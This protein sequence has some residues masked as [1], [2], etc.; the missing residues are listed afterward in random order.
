MQDGRADRYNAFITRTDFR[1]K[2]SGSLSSLRI[3]VKDNIDVEGMPTTAAS[4]ILRDNMPGGSAPVVRRLLNEGALITGK[5]NMHEFAIGATTT[6]TAAGPCLNPHDTARICGGSS[7]G[8]AAC[9]AGGLSDIALG[10]DTGGS[11]RLPAALCGVLGFKPTTGTISAEGVIPLSTTFDT[12]GI[13]G[14]GMDAVKLAFGTICERR[15][16][17]REWSPPERRIKLGLLGFGDDE[18][19]GGLLA[20]IGRLRERFDIS[21]AEIPLLSA[22][23]ARVRRIVTSYEGARYHAKWMAERSGEYFPDVLS[24]LQFGS[25][26]TD[27]EY[28]RGLIELGAIREDFEEKMKG[29]D[30]L[31]APTVA[32]VAPHISEVLGHELDY[33]KMLANTELFS[34]TGSPSISI[35]AAKVHGLPCGL[36]VSGEASG[37]MKILEIAGMLLDASRA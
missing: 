7:G 9:V 21:A 26:I 31:L 18:V 24:V 28:G 3:G 5:T 20:F 6:S 11:V 10:T 30:A 35:P 29:F 33:R 15:E 2:D 37:D 4:R 22:D 8:S 13:L 25:K 36:M 1:T 34:A 23:G 16:A 32:M 17:L 12:V 14:T 27:E 19:S